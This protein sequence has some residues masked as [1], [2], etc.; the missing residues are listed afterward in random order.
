MFSD[1]GYD[2]ARSANRT[3]T[4]D[5]VNVFQ[6]SLSNEYYLAAKH[7]GLNRAEVVELA[8][9]AVA[10][11]FEEPKSH[12]KNKLPT[13]LAKKQLRGMFEEFRDEHLNL[14][15]LQGYL[16]RRRERGDKVVRS[17]IR[18]LAALKLG[19]SHNDSGTESAKSM[20]GYSASH[21]SQSV[22]K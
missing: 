14:V 20:S 8:E 2:S 13:Y 17:N 19:E 15:E 4:G 3:Q 18:D 6:T 5:Y 21:E 22:K 11:S 12:D 9:N 10:L 7:F 16:R 1:T